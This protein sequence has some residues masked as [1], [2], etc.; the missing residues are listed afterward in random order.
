MAQ[1]RNGGSR[2]KY[3]ICLNTEDDC[4]M[5]KAINNKKGKPVQEVRGS[6]PFECS[7]CG[8]ELKEVAAPA[9]PLN[10]KL[11]AGCV[12]GV[13]LLSGVG[14]FVMNINSPEVTSPKP[15]VDTVIA[16][17]PDPAEGVV[18]PNTEPVEASDP[19]VVEPS[20]ALVLDYAT[21][22][23]S[24]RNGK[25]HGQG[26]MLFT[27][28]KLIDSRDIEKKRTASAGEKII[29]EYKDGRLVHGTWYKGDGNVETIVIGG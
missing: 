5:S 13:L 17:Q 19:V 28:T 12:A 10:L 7:K 22:S 21:W 29:G 27:K 1:E 26:V 25:A 9:T 4:E 18:P 11:I 20:D 8:E 2:L 23:G 3:G 16:A 14:A 24:V 15:E 6:K